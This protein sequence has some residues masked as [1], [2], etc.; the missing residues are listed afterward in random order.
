MLTLEEK[1]ILYSIISN[2]T[3]EGQAPS[4]EKHLQSKL[5]EQ[6]NNLPIQFQQKLVNLI[7]K[8]SNNFKPK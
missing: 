3:S 2:N 4:K 7:S 6:I 1:E 5:N 8:S